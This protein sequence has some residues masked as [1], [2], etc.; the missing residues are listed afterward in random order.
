MR[1]VVAPGGR[2]DLGPVDVDRVVAID[3]DVHIAATP[4]RPSPAPERVDDGHTRGEGHAGEEGI[5]HTQGRRR[6]VIGRR[7][8]RVGPRAIDHARVVGRH[9]DGLRIG[10]GDAVDLPRWRHAGGINLLSEPTIRCCRGTVAGLRDH[11]L[12]AAPQLAGGIGAGAERLH[13]VHHIGLLGEHRIAQPLGPVQLLVHHGQHRREGHQGFY[14]RVPGLGLQRFAQAIAFQRGIAT[15]LQPAF[16]L[17]QFQR[18]GR[19]H[20]H[21]HQQVIGIQRDRR[22]QRFQLALGQRLGDGCGGGGLG[23]G[24]R[25]P[26]TAQQ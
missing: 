7:I 26:G 6:R 22:Q 25:R 21:L 12:R 15:L 14:R 24:R 23:P 5:A 4:G 1:H 9:I 20:Q 17:H 19:R 18:I 8:G 10:R 2:V 3:V 16:G 11:L 13:G